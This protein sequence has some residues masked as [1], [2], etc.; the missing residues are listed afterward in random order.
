MQHVT[1]VRAT[2]PTITDQYDLLVTPP[3]TT[4]LHIPRRRHTALLR[5]LETLLISWTRRRSMESRRIPPDSLQWET[6]S[7]RAARLDPYLYI[8]SISG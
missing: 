5:V 1:A 3:T 4:P 7:E 6:P 2:T 8:L